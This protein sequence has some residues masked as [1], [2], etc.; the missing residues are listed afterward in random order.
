MVSQLLP[1][2]GFP[3]VPVI[4]AVG[5]YDLEGIHWYRRDS[6]FQG[7]DESCTRVSFHDVPPLAKQGVKA[8]HVASLHA[9]CDTLYIWR[10][11]AQEVNIWDSWSHAG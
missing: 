9:V 8:V 3:E 1:V 6:N 5:N 7:C 11:Q 4:P 10:G 2:V